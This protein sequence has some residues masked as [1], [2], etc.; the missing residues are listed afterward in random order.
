MALAD[1]FQF[2]HTQSDDVRAK[3]RGPA[4]VQNVKKLLRSHEVVIADKYG[5]LLYILLGTQVDHRN[6]HLRKHR[7]DLRDAVKGMYPPVR[8]L[9]LNWSLDQPHAAIHR[10]C[11]DRILERGTNHQT[12]HGDTTSKLHEDVLWQF[13]RNTESLNDNEADA[14]VEMDI[15]ED[16]EGSL[17][18]AIDGI[19]RILGL[20]RPDVERVGAALAKAHGYKPARTDAKQA[21]KELVAPRYF[22]LLAEVDLVDALD[23]HL[24]RQEGPLREFWDMLKVQGRVARCP[25]VTIV[26]SKHLPEKVTL[27][28]R[29]ATLHALSAP[30]LFRARLGHVVANER[31]VAA[32]VDD[33]SVDNPEEDVGQEGSSFVSQLDPGLRRRLHITIGTKDASVLPV[34]AGT[35]V[36]SFREGKK[37]LDS[38]PLE[39][40]HVKGRIKGLFN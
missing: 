31:I 23:A 28:E 7:E 8:L 4:F 37:G 10:I 1:L 22:G 40:V 39:E 2:G 17:A 29:C 16:L 5:I 11:A 38:I 13:L 19:V 30:P 21:A 24:T 34:E 15:G 27:W 32:T 14:T 3:K 6:N 12:L 25:H 20:P 36:E 18:R 26:H 33:L 9:A 35:L